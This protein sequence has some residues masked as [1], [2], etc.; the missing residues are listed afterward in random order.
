[1]KI[2]PR[3]Y[4]LNILQTKTQKQA[5]E[6]LGISTRTIRRITA[7]VDYFRRAKPEMVRSIVDMGKR[8]RKRLQHPSKRV[9]VDRAE[10][11]REHQ[12]SNK[13]LLSKD[14]ERARVHVPKAIKVVPPVQRLTRIDPSDPKLKRRKWADT[15]SFDVRKMKLDDVRGVLEAYRNV[16]GAQ[17]NIVYA[18]PGGTPAY[19][20]AKQSAS[21]WERVG[22]MKQKRQN[23]PARSKD[24]VEKTLI[25]ASL[26]ARG[27]KYKSKQA[28][29]IKFIQIQIS[30]P[31][32]K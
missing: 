20:R 14:K 6:L 23:I 30:K 21:G 10:A 17:I 18:T 11:T 22:G 15:I 29:N 8:E 7:N 31:T 28:H 16:P 26:Q 1:M 19:P 4:L 32:R 9:L 25:Q 5:S 3:D 27:K 2:S 12:H 13:K 24:Y